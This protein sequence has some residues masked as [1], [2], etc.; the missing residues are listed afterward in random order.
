VN[1]LGRITDIPS[2]GVPGAASGLPSNR[3]GAVKAAICEGV[4]RHANAHFPR[5]LRSIVLTG[6]LARSEATCLER[7][8][9]FEIL[10]D[11]EFFLVFVDKAD[12]PCSSE[13]ESVA[14]E[15]EATLRE[16][17]IH[18]H[19]SLGAVRPRYFRRLRPNV[20]SYELAACGQVVWGDRE[21]LNLIPSFSPVE[22][23]L[24]D[25]WRT[26]CNRLIEQL[27]AVEE[28]SARPSACT[29]LHYRTVKLYLDMTTSLLVFLKA[30]EPSYLRRAEKLNL[31]ACDP[32]GKERFPF[33]LPPFAEQVAACTAYKLSGTTHA[34]LLPSKDDLA[35]VLSFWKR[36]VSFARQLWRW[37]LTRL[38]GGWEPFS[39]Y[40]LMK[41]WMGTQPLSHRVRGWLH[42]VRKCGW[43]RSRSHWLRWAK[44]GWRGSPRYCLYEVASHASFR[45]PEI[46]GESEGRTVSDPYWRTLCAGVPLCEAA[47]D[48][49]NGTTWQEVVRSVAANYR[50]FLTDTR[51]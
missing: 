25:G 35:G 18:C 34:Q 42:V 15:A 29:L 51:A 2:F 5:R 41:K 40:V 31:L 23:P 1:S 49:G 32:S 36:S 21:I 27:E 37:E 44:V 43:V 33:P 11:A 46:V 30:Y 3:L 12:L 45:L 13:I 28:V 14:R 10:G 48:N 26:L 16:Q 38:T 50:D 22:I 39:D 4:A 47:K 7:T 8:E 9:S 24:E 19:V 6:S 17:A 20:F